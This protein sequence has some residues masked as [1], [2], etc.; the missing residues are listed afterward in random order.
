MAVTIDSDSAIVIFFT[1]FSSTK[2]KLRRIDLLDKFLDEK[3][4]PGLKDFLIFPR[5]GGLQDKGLHLV[6]NIV[7][8]PKR[9]KA[10]V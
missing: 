10:R 8:I 6:G 3:L 2:K 7:A 9:K 4:Q 5:N 1:V